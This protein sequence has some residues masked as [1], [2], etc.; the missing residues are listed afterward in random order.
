MFLFTGHLVLG[1]IPDNGIDLILIPISI[2]NSIGMNRHQSLSRCM[3]LLVKVTVF[4]WPYQF[5]WGFLMFLFFLLGKAKSTPSLVT[6]TGAWQ[7]YLIPE[8]QVRHGLHISPEVL[9]LSPDRRGV[10]TAWAAHWLIGG[11]GG[12]RSREDCLQLW[13]FSLDILHT[14]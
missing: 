10:V 12:V 11:P 4:A 5:W 2:S 14:F 3:K 8:S 13:W 1:T 7:Q 6:K 9:V